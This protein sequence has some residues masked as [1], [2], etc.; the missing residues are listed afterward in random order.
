MLGDCSIRAILM[1]E[2]E[3]VLVAMPHSVSELVES[4]TPF[5]PLL[6]KSNLRTVY[7]L[8]VKE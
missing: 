7:L 4:V 2:N 6:I 3:E 8:T 1:L 5:I